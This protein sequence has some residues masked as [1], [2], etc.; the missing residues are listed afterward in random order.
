MK[1]AGT[2]LRMELHPETD[3]ER[4]FLQSALDERREH[5]AH[6]LLYWGDADLGGGA[7]IINGHDTP[8]GESPAVVG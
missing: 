5:R 1:L 3:E 2:P 6:D 4:D 7:F 8:V